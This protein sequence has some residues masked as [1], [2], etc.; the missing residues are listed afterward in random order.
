MIRV[1][2]GS[3]EGRIKREDERRFTM[4]LEKR[5]R[6]E[7]RRFEREVGIAREIKRKKQRLREGNG[8]TRE[9]IGCEKTR[10]KA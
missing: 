2:A 10:N 9:T 1:K 7:E 5:G 6:E 3:V 4:R 8:L